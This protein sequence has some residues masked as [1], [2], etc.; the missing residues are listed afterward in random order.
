[1]NITRADILRSASATMLGGALGAFAYPREA[2]AQDLA[3]VSIGIV[4]SSS[5]APFFIA[6][7]LGFFR[8]AGIN[9]QFTN[10][11]GA[12]QMIAPLGTGQLDV[13]S[14]SPS[15]GFY[16]GVARGIDIRMVA[17][18]AYSPVGSGYNP[19]MIRTSLVKSGQYKSPKDLRGMRIAEPAKGG[20]TAAA[21]AKLLESVGLSYNDVTHVFLS[22]PDQ[23]AA[24]AT[25]AIDGT[26]LNEPGATLAERNGVA[27][28]VLSNDKWYPNQDQAEVFFGSSFIKSRP[29][30]GMRFMVAWLRAARFY[31]DGLLNGRLR[32]KNGPQIIDILTQATP[33]KDRSIYSSMTSQAVNPNGTINIRTLTDDLAFYK[34][35]G[36]LI[37]D[38]GVSAATDL[39]F[40]QAALRQLGPYQP[41]DH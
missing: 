35:N 32:G 10:F 12:P 4:S 33:I 15:A 31:T 3:T 37:G 40:Q 34:N 24:L 9:P 27:V 17:N 41:N 11:D 18:K 29:E 36:Y 16:N 25:G 23:V 13:G 38:V 28:R 7:K 21:L 8:A 14:G 22:F 5:D 20:T 30:V 6:D 26:L 2:S 1:V 39:S 19:L